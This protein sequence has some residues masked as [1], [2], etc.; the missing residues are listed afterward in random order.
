MSKP[1]LQPGELLDG[2]YEIV[3]QI[4]EGGMGVVF[5]AHHKGL[6][7]RVAVKVLRSADLGEDSEFRVR[8]T[9]EARVMSRL[10]HPNAVTVYDH[11]EHNGALYIAME[12][13]EG[14]PLDDELG[15]GALEMRRALIIAE[16]ICDVLTVTHEMGLVHRDIKPENIFI[17]ETEEGPL[18]TLVDFGLAF[19]ASDEDLSRMTRDGTLAGT[20]L[21]LSPEQASA[22]R[23]LGPP[24]DIY[25][26]GCVLY[27]LLC[28][29]PVVEGDTVLALLNAHVFVP[30]QS[31]RVKAPDSAVPAT[32]DNFVLS[33]LSKSPDARPSAFEAATFLRKML[34]SESMRGRGRPMRLLQPRAQRAVT[35]AAGEAAIA[36]AD[37]L[38]GAATGV[39]KQAT[40]VLGVIG[41]ISDELRV[42]AHMSGWEPREWVAGQPYHVVLALAPEAVTREIAQK[43]TTMSVADPNSIEGAVRLL[44]LGV[45][46]LAVRGE[47]DEMMRK[48]DRLDNSRRRRGLK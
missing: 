23:S 20:P 46:D 41:S 14:H 42:A 32:L 2:K 43:Y 40:R 28:G 19:I 15:D 13:L 34:A 5:E 3:G 11:G 31:I 30:A 47:I 9:R 1:L 22:S 21:Y 25:S 33:M 44:K 10:D 48:A 26:M 8:F 12:F 6:D 36:G 24:S 39:A 4:G 7:R 17:T 27:E 38:V 35:A 45:Q 16:Q 37:T 29:E 18:A